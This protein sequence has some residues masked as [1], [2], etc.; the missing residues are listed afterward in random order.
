ML[1]TLT[2]R[3]EYHPT[4]TPRP[5]GFMVFDG[6]RKVG[7]M[8]EAEVRAALARFDEMKTPFSKG[9]TQK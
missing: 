8:T 7:V 4:T 9:P 6:D 3:V 2:L 1:P 5:I